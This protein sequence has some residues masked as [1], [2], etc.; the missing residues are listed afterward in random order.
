VDI[1]S[2][3][4]VLPLNHMKDD[5]DGWGGQLAHDALQL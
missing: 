3:K 1:K 4:F 5:Y 2:F